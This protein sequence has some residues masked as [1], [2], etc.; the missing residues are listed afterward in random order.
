MK[1]PTLTEQ[2]LLICVSIIFIVI[3]SLG[4]VLPRTLLPVYE[5]NLY[6]YLNQSLSL[7]EKVDNNKINS[8][9]AYIYIDSD[10]NVF[11]SNNLSSVININ[12]ID[13]LLDNINDI[14]GKF[15]YKNKIYYY[16]TES[17][18]NIKKIAITGSS[19]I[20]FMRAEILK[21]ILIV[22]G[23]TFVIISLLV[24]I[25]SNH[26]V[27]RIKKL[28]DKIDN[29]NNNDYDH[30]MIYD[31]DDELYTLEVAIENMRVYLKEQDEYKNQMYQNIS[32]DFKTPITVM[33]SYIEASEDGVETK[34]KTLDICKEQLN[35][36]EVK[37]HSLLYLNKLNYFSQQKDSIKRSCDVSK[38]ILASVE[39]FTPS[40]S[41]VEF[42]LDI[43][44]KNVIFRGSE[45]MW[46]AIIDNILNNFMR[47]ARTKI[48]ITVKNNKI[49][50]Y[51][52]GPNIDKTVLNNIFTPYEKGVNGVFGLGLSIVKK[53]LLLLNYDIN[54]TNEK[55]G[56]KFIIS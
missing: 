33:K 15:V 9:I 42:V 44:K 36:L 12:S 7:L 5:E 50:L 3:I 25:W 23:I 1:K 45:E 6:N 54:I 48:K 14:K 35:K 47:Y 29:I 18:N 27:N 2:L 53:T 40:R 38:I 20:N 49:I 26:L 31:Y 46:E 52:D 19:Y 8:E 32:H 30:K 4:I 37:V 22:V 16:A 34:E 10:N 11:V 55:N 43:D 51:N 56:V 13:K 17:N 21:I 28:K 24:L 39:K 41:D